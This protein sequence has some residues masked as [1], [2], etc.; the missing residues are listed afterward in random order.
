[1]RSVAAR[2]SLGGAGWRR[3]S[4]RGSGWLMSSV[5][6]A[7]E[8][9]AKLSASRAVGSWY[10]TMDDVAVVKFPIE[11]GEVGDDPWS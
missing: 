8:K 11:L 7:K 3:F 2:W 4:R 1:M 9:L 5:G 6:C 10:M